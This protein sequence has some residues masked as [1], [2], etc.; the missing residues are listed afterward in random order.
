MS[1]SPR[2]V[3]RAGERAREEV[4]TAYLVGDIFAE[5]VDDEIERWNGLMGPHRGVSET[6]LSAVR[7]GRP[8]S[9]RSRWRAPAGSWQRASAP[10]APFRRYCRLR[11][12]VPSQPVENAVD[13]I[14]ERSGE[15]RTRVPACLNGPHQI[16][17]QRQM[18]GQPSAESGSR[19]SG[20]CL[21]R[22]QLWKPPGL[23]A[24]GTEDE[25]GLESVNRLGDLVDISK[26]QLQE[27]DFAR[28][29][30]GHGTESSEVAAG[31]PSFRIAAGSYD[32]AHPFLA[33]QEL[34][35]YPTQMPEADNQDRRFRHESIIPV[36]VTIVDLDLSVQ[37]HD[38]WKRREE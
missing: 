17:I 8:A 22:K 33:R 7:G 19:Q 24:R 26:V 6:P 35:S 27:L 12:S 10:S 20:G 38:L 3:L 37:F 34:E 36:P 31:S 15:D 23:R 25:I 1:E 2:L 28:V 29:T 16:Q 30:L 5:V 9:P 21:L 18:D 32:L 13:D 4:A 11:R 14:W